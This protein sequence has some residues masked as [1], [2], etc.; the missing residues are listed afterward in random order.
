MDG[1]IWMWMWMEGN[2]KEKKVCV[3]GCGKVLYVVW[4]G[5]VFREG[6]CWWDMLCV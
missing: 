5:Y 6:F 3:N 1:W 4:F 2:W